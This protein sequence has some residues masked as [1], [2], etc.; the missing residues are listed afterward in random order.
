MIINNH[1]DHNRIIKKGAYW[2]GHCLQFVF[3]D[4]VSFC[5]P[6][7]S[8]SYSS[9]FTFLIRSF[10]SNIQYIIPGQF[11]LPQRTISALLDP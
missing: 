2:V 11:K 10:W 9:S 6:S 1:D 5:N 7:F 4:I 8:S 3:S